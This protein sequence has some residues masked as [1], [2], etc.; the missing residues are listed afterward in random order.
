MRK[1]YLT[2]GEDERKKTTTTRKQCFII[3]SVPGT[4]DYV[5]NSLAQSR[6]D[7]HWIP[8]NPKRHFSLWVSCF[9]GCH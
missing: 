5:C 6:K 3:L 7:F 8:L 4:S 1:H 2:L 9:K